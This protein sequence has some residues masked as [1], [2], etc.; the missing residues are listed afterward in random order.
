MHSMHFC[1]SSGGTPEVVYM[2]S[3]EKYNPKSIMLLEFPPK[4]LKSQDLENICPGI[5]ATC[6]WDIRSRT[7]F[8]IVD[9]KFKGP[10]L[11]SQ[12]QVY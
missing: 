7:S 9:S 3:R 12:R 5:L 4:I 6:A 1:Q 8:Q 2:N 11:W 10:W